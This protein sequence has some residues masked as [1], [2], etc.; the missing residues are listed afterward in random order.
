MAEAPHLLVLIVLVAL[1]AAWSPRPAAR[2]LGAVFVAAAVLHLELAATGWLYRYEAYLVAWGLVLLALLLVPSEGAVVTLAP[3]PARALV[4][5][6]LGV[7]AV[8][9]VARGI[10]AAWE[11][12]RAC[13][14]VY[15]QQYQ[16]GRF[17]ARHYP[18]ATVMAN[19][20]GAVSYLADVHLVDLYGLA[21]RETAAARR[22]GRLDRRFLEDLTTTA[23]PEVVVVYRSWFAD[24]LPASWIEVGTWR[25]P[26][27]VVVAD[28]SVS[29]LAP[30]EPAARRL[31][32]A[33]AAFEAE[34][35]AR[36]AARTAGP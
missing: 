30:G 5:A 3:R 20:V 8:P 17:L 36:V 13:R 23:R 33:L 32:D 11:A 27:K 15:E 4:A 31:R 1:A 16:M 14:N 19:D 2:P 35:P 26:E 29:F 7:A 18:G 9:F 21:T 24:S 10:Q 6:A 12:P 25:V 34:L 28:R 22:A